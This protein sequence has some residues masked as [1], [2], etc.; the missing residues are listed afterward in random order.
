MTSNAPKY[1]FF[2]PQPGAPTYAEHA[3]GLDEHRIVEWFDRLTQ[4]REAAIQA[5]IETIRLATGDEIPRVV[6]AIRVDTAPRNTVTQRYM[7]ECLGIE[8][9]NS[10]DLDHMSLEETHD[11]LWTIIYGLARLNSFLVNTDHLSDEKLLD[12]LVSSV[13]LDEIPLVV[14][15]SEMSEFLD[16]GCRDNGLFKR[17]Q[18]LPRPNRPFDPDEAVA[19]VKFPPILH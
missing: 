13:L 9:P 2:K 14:P 17:D 5:E 3:P 15:N 4:N 10:E 16:M 11:A 6:A 12:R 8:V 19:V 1:F 18:F 7:L